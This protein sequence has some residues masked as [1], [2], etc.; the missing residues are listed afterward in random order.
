M[1]LLWLGKA[2]E[3]SKVKSRKGKPEP[4]ERKL[5]EARSSKMSCSRSAAAALLQ[6][7]HNEMAARRVSDLR[8]MMILIGPEHGCLWLARSR[9]VAY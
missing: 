6:L 8:L 4:L 2:S 7:T 1:A 9:V 3:G 5:N